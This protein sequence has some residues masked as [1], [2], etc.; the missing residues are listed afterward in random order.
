MS[1][2]IKSGAGGRDEISTAA[3]AVQG[4]TVQHASTASRAADRLS[5][6]LKANQEDIDDHQDGRAFDN[7]RVCAS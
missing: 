1:A 4:V 2:H 7:D 3:G 5:G 6:V